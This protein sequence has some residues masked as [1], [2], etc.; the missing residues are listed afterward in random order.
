MSFNNTENHDNDDE[1]SGGDEGKEKGSFQ[2]SEK[3]VLLQSSPSTD[4]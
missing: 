1:V 2:V 3:L 4:G